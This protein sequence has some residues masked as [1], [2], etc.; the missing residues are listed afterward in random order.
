MDG[1]NDDYEARAPYLIAA[2]CTEMTE[3]DAY[4]RRESESEPVAYDAVCVSLDAPFP[5]SPRLCPAA[6]LYVA[7]MLILDSDE[8]RS[9]KL[10][11]QYSTALGRLASSM[12][13]ENSG[14]PTSLWE[15]HKIIN[16]YF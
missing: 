15:S 6:V 10:Y 14:L 8:E 13:F 9:D 3:L 11:A 5:L 4:M 1:E 12:G 16:K 2:F 7:A